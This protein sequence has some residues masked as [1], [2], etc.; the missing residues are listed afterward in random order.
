MGGEAGGGMGGVGGGMA[1]EEETR[2]HAEGSESGGAAR[3]MQRE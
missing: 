1:C 3:A 2:R